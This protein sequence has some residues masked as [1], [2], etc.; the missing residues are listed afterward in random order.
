M[1]CHDEQ[2]KDTDAQLEEETIESDQEETIHDCESDGE[3]EKP[4]PEREEPEPR[5]LSSLS[6]LSSTARPQSGLGLILSNYW[7][8][9]EEL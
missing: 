1:P 2:S 8:S 4:L 6:S 3:E 9:D 5:L 7:S